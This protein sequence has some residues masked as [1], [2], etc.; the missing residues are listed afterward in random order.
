MHNQRKALIVC[1]NYQRTPECAL[2][3]CINDGINMK[4]VLID[5]FGY[6]ESNI[7]FLRDDVENEVE[8]PT[9][10][11]I[12]RGLTDLISD[13]ANC[14]QIFVHYSGHGSQVRDL[15]GDEK[16]GFDS[17]IV[18]MDYQS[19]GLI[20]DDILLSYIRESKCPT[21]TVFDSCNSGTVIDLPYSLLYN[22][23]LKKLNLNSNNNYKISNENIISI[24]G[25]RDNQTS[26]DAYQDNA[27]GGALTSALLKTLKAANYTGSVQKIYIS[28]LLLLVKQGF[29]QRP[30]LSGSSSKMNFMFRRMTPKTVKLLNED[31][32][33]GKPVDVIPESTAGVLSPE[34]SQAPNTSN[35]S[36]SIAL[37]TAASAKPSRI[38]DIMPVTMTHSQ[39]VTSIH[40]MQ[41]TSSSIVAK[42]AN[43][44]H[45]KTSNTNYKFMGALVNK[46][47]QV[48][49]NQ[50]KRFDKG[51]KRIE[52]TKIMTNAKIAA[53]NMRFMF[54]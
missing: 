7:T 15:S 6:L 1:I 9:A 40:E 2:N 41:G 36:T 44:L 20:V 19:A 26:A 34:T 4:N 29:S 14:D 38:I 22:V 18:P 10:A 16:S 30:I 52:T 39:V 48:D 37:L 33:G 11:N 53:S 32:T 24:S 43:D 28:T 47:G 27:Y 23:P 12:M 50:D 35:L 45:L 5:Y 42:I 25:C 49:E 31:L 54:L 46:Q 8:L 51:R 21:M 3:G 13:S 17:V